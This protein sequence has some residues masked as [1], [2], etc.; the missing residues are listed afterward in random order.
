[1]RVSLSFF[2]TSSS[3]CSLHLSL[4]LKCLW[5]FNRHNIDHCLIVLS[6]LSSIILSVLLPL[7][8]IFRWVDSSLIF[9][10]QTQHWKRGKQFLSFSK[11]IYLWVKALFLHSELSISSSFL[12]M[13]FA[14]LNWFCPFSNEKRE[15]VIYDDCN[16]NL[17]FLTKWKSQPVNTGR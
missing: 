7:R 16:G 3:I 10:K 4:W 5:I 12:V 13:N 15:M 1:M 2:S 14:S 11:I 6:H 17:K 9:S 8:V